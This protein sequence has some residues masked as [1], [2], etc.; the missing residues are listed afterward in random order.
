MK[1][2]IAI[3][4]AFISFGAMAQLKGT[5]LGSNG[6]VQEPIEGAKVYLL[7]AK[8]GDI[9]CDAG[10]FELILPRTLPDTLVFS[11]LGYISDTVVVTKED[12]F[13]N[14]KVVLFADEVLPEI[15]VEYRKNTKTISKLK[16]LAVEEISLGELRKA[17]CC[18]LSE[19][20]ET[21]VS[22]DVNFTD[23]VSG[24]RT[25][26]M[27]G[28]EGVYTQIQFENI[29]YLRG[30]E[31]PFGLSSFPGTW[32]NS[33]QITKG[34]G[35]VV[36]GYESMAGLVNIEMFKPQ[37]MDAFFLNGY[38]NIYGRAELNA[39]GSM[40]VSK[41]WSTALFAHGSGMFA[42]NN[43][44]HDNFMDAPMGTLFSFNNRW[45]YQGEKMEAQIGVNS[46]LE[47]KYGGEVGYRK[48]ANN[49]LYGMETDAKHLDVY[50]KTGFFMKKPY[51][52][53]GVI[54]NLKYQENDALFGVRQFRGVEKRGYVNGVFE[55]II[56]NTMHKYKVGL[57]GVF[58][59]MDQQMDS[60][61]D[62]RVEIV[63]GA[64]AEYTYTG[65]RLTTVIGARGD[66]HNLYNFQFSPRVHAKYAITEFT[67][68]RVTAGKGWRVPNYMIDNISLLA[69][70]RQ[71][72]APTETLPE[73]SWNFG[74][75]LVQSFKLFGN[76]ASVVV[77]YYH[78]L[79]ERQLIV[80]RDENVHQIIFRNMTSKSFS[81]S[82]QTEFSFTPFSRFDI[83][84][85][86]KFLD[87][88]AE[89][90]G[91]LQQKVMVPKHR[92]FINVAYHT[93]NNKWEFDVT[94]SV[95]GTSRLPVAQLDSVTFTTDNH[96][97]VYPQL[98]AQITYK[99]KKWDFYIGGENLTNYRQNHPII[100]AENPFGTYFDATR[101]W[102]PVMGIN[103]YAG[104]RYVIAHKK[105]E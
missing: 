90:G 72:I 55:S 13:I 104:F 3:A 101:I 69:T 32:I 52:S 4:F 81:N 23:A 102:A 12:R 94:A 41:K 9:T 92:G 71:W 62:N 98:S 7:N 77:D 79:F 1:N 59:D 15:I 61:T 66:Y 97:K 40:H 65:P 21:N 26:Q 31:Q 56:G 2:S 24:A 48:G 82:F 18:N 60:L 42:E 67:D 103:V 100:D 70:S 80:D 87:V 85:A 58:I 44:N 8:T 95:F 43:H 36:N 5:V 20:F 57:S 68:L 76:Q 73:I 17:A 86:Y 34:T 46:Y 14:M 105:Q 54:Y 6:S 10:N 22:V 16:V 38:G 30:L 78:T 50:A 45:H 28:L 33:I 84:L 99:H 93:R 96:S 29:P 51:N 37:D 89:Y 25:I 11:A 75:S 47:S 64:F 74:G 83:R 19:S 49:G 91:Q 88:R 53:I 27:M 35:N 63:P 39:H